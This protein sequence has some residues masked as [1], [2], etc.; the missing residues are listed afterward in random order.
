[1][2]SEDVQSAIKYIHK[3]FFETS[4]YKD[5]N[6]FIAGYGTVG[7]ALVDII[8]R[9]RDKIAERTG[10]RLH[11]AGISNSAWRIKSLVD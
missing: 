7:K 11:I 2:A 5:I 3:E 6:L 9:N 10:K 1:M 8:A 4:S